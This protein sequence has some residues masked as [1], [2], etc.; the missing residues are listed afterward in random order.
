MEQSLVG[1]HRNIELLT[2]S[3]LKELNGDA[4]NFTA[5]VVQHARYVD[6][7]K[8]TGCG[9]C[10]LVCPVTHISAFPFKADD[11]PK[12]KRLRAKDKRIIACEAP[13]EPTAEHAWTFTVDEEK[14]S[15]CGACH[16]AC[17]QDAIT[18]QKKEYASINQDKC[19][20]CGA[21]LVACPDKDQ[22]ITVSDAPELEKSLGAA[23]SE[24]S[25]RLKQSFFKRESKD[26][27][28]CGLCAITC[29]NVMKIGALRMVEEGIQAGVDICQVCGA[30]VSHC[31]VDFLSMDKVT[32]KVPLPSGGHRFSSRFYR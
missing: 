9:L 16:R 30:C 21:C 20:G 32:S 28:R 23:I 19:T 26:C 10:E 2:H 4:G 18:W 6:V 17:L 12:K 13:V 31:P 29:K 15:Q 3:E 14:C 11:E 1:R 7:D 22:A 25:F 8:C 24:R 5:K 27:V